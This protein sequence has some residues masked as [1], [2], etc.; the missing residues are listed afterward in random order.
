M[1]YMEQVAKM[2]GVE[3]GEEFE[4]AGSSF[5]YKL[6]EDK[7]VLYYNAFYERWFNDFGVLNRILVGSR[8][9]VRKPYKPKYKERYYYVGAGGCVISTI[10][11]DNA[12][13]HYYNFN[14]GNCFRTAEEITEEMKRGIVKKMKEKYES[15]E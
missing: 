13:I 15:E 9:I 7:G 1:N 5:K 11:D 3:I 12:V 14:C 8:E 2:L 6:S 4:L 10:F